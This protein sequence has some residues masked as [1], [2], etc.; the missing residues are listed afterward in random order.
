MLKKQARQVFIEKRK[1]VT[2]TQRQKWD[3][4]LLIQFQRLALP[5]IET[6]MTFQS[7]ENFNEPATDAITDYLIFSNPG[8]QV[9]YPVCDF[10][11]S[12]MRAFVTEDDTTFMPNRFGTL[13]PESNVEMSPASID[14]IIVPLLCF[15][16]AGYR[17]GFGKGFYDKFLSSPG[18]RAVKVGLSY[19]E[20]IDKIVN[21]NHF[22]VPLDYCITPERIY[23]FEQNH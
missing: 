21:S 8:V 5:P 11:T 19:F 6:L 12:T 14:L 20:P 13:E 22:D 15:D 23:G 10:A 7:M 16:K 3:D 18:M 1:G 2:G 4:L 17:V 9:A